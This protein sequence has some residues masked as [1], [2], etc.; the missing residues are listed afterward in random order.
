[1]FY[2]G[3]DLGGTNIAVGL[4][5]EEGKILHKCSAPTGVERG[6]EAVIEDM[7]KLCKR[8]IAETGHAV[9][10]IKSIGVGVPGICHPTNGVVEFCTNLYWHNVPLCDIMHRYIAV[11]VFIGNDATVAGFAESMVGVS[12]GV[13]NSVFITLGTGVGGGIVIDNK[14]Y[15]GTHG[16][17]SELG[18]MIIREG[19][20]ECTCGNRGCWERYT[21]ATAMIRMGREAMESH[22][23]S[24][25]FRECGG[26]PEKL[27][28]K[29]VM[30]AAKANDP[31]AM[32]VFKKY[33][34]Y[35]AVG[36]ITIINALD[37]E[38][39]A[40]GGGVSAAGPF[41][42]DAV[43]AEVDAMVFC[44]EVP[45]ARI[46]LAVLGNDAGIIGAALLGKQ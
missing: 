31:A 29:N 23:D 8:L 1:M 38:V 28:A 24:L 13:A 6:P 32:E 18:H 17:G 12:R 42:R 19:G 36:I 45:Y 46:E 14:V 39:I 30:D 5:D 44:K 20:V 25:M 11:P 7:T 34:H 10:E 15:S 4:V 27:N 21:S 16:I 2:I 33:V 26:E 40:L 35:L 9:S 22:P 37:P 41:L 3:V 43:R